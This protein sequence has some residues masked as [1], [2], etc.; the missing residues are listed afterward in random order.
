MKTGCDLKVEL[1]FWV[2]QCNLSKTTS[3]MTFIDVCFGFVLDWSPI[4]HQSLTT[5]IPS[6]L[7]MTQI[8]WT[9]NER[10]FKGGMN[11]VF[12]Q[13]IP[14]L[15]ISARIQYVLTP[16]QPFTR[17]MVWFWLTLLMQTI[18]GTTIIGRALLLNSVLEEESQVW[19]AL[20]LFLSLFTWKKY[21]RSRCILL[22]NLA[23]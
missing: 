23:L 4:F 1:D 5:T 18:L 8:G 7:N 13:I 22:V 16:W 2:S 10:S 15:G 6:T 21:T 14:P 9:G 17:M 19:F 20:P 11:I 3:P 12:V